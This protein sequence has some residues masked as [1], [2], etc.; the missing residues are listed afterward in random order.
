MSNWK[1]DIDDVHSFI[2][3]D[4]ESESAEILRDLLNGDYSIEALRQDFNE[5]Y[6]NKAHQY[7][8]GGVGG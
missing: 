6:N 3:F 2:G 1:V 7:F 5:F 8:D 4:N